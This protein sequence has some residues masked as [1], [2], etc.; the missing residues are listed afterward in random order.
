MQLKF[1]HS[2]PVLGVIEEVQIVAALSHMDNVLAVDGV[3][4]HRA[5][6]RLSDSQTIRIV[7]K[8]GGSAGLGICL[9]WRPFSQV[10]D[11]V[12]S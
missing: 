10:Y 2:R 6:H 5:T 7:E 12:P 9:G 4:S 8:G 1:H 11:Q 3:I